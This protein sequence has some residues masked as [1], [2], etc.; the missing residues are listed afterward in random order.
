MSIKRRIRKDEDK[1]RRMCS[2]K[3][4]YLNENSALV[5]IKKAQQRNQIGLNCYRCTLCG[6]YHITKRNYKT[7]KEGIENV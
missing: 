7:E 5:V 3:V 4:R 1:A 6:S 2:G